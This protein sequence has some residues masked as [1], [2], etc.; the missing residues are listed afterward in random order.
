MTEPFRFT[1][2]WNH[3]ISIILLV[4][5]RENSNVQGDAMWSHVD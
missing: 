2:Y 5:K 3:E 1:E 4:E